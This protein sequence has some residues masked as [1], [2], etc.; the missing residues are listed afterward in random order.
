MRKLTIILVA[1]A[2]TA[3]ACGGG[4]GGEVAATVNG[5]D[6]TVEDVRSF[7]HDTSA[8]IAAGE[9]AQ[10]L[11][12][13]I[14]WQILD[15]AAAEEFGVDPTDEQVDQE[16]ETVLAEQADGATLEEL[17]EA[18]NLS[19]ETV[20]RIVRV[21]LIQEQVSAELA[22]TLPE[23]TQE[24]LNRAV[25]TERAGMTEVC[26]RHILVATAEEAE[27]A[28]ARIEGGEDFADVAAEVST[29][30]GSGE[31]GGDLGCALAQNYVPEFQEASV[32]AEIDEVTEPVQS[33]FGFHLIQVYER[34]GP[35]ESALSS[36]DELRAALVEEAGFV[37]LQDWLL[38]KVNEAEV[39]VDEEYGTW[40]LEPQPG[41]Q[42]PTT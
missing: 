21:G 22:E 5:A 3:T 15:A 33:Q 10:Y 23:P 28:R 17:A 12:A 34:T 2:A 16:M 9:F 37:A 42:P 6:V 31:N 30:P 4:G 8:T 26:A 25:E 13:L 36:E 20:R 18:Q 11:G 14:Q 19:E 39:T 41:V 7:P 38:E 32:N 35:E 27:E 40:T 1:V 24:Q 29:D